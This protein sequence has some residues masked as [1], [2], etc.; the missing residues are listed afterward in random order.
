[1]EPKKH[2]FSPLERKH[3]LD[4]LKKYSTFIE[5]KD[6]DGATLKTKNEAWSRITAEYNASPLASKQAT[7]KQLRRLWINTKQRQREAL[8]KERQHRL[9]TGGGPS[10]SDAVIDPDVSMV[11]PALIVG[12]DNAVD[13][14]VVEDLQSQLTASMEIENTTSYYVLPDV[15][16]AISLE[17]PVENLQPEPSTSQ[18]SQPSITTIPSG[19]SANN[20]T[21]L[22]K[23]NIIEQEYKDRYVRATEKHDMEMLILKQQLREAKAKAD[24]AELIFKEK[25]NS[26][27]QASN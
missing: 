11:A 9:S 26:A 1:M 5:N 27:G 19:R 3:F 15:T 14:D 21:V 23:N 24:L 12:I 20:R 2:V 17:E 6:T 10:I 18:M 13:S 22:V 25:L 8:T 7:T 16:P 4:I